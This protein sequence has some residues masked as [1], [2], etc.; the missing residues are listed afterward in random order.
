MLKKS[1]KTEESV[2]LVFVNNQNVISHEENG[3]HGFFKQK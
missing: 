3:N 1:F 2:F